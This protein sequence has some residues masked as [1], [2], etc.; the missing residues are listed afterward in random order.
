MRSAIEIGC[1]EWPTHIFIFR[2]R[3]IYV[4]VLQTQTC[5]SW[6]L[7]SVST[8]PTRVR[9]RTTSTA[10]RKPASRGFPRVPLRTTSR[11]PLVH[12]ELPNVLDS[13]DIPKEIMVDL[14]DLWEWER[15]PLKQVYLADGTKVKVKKVSSTALRT[16]VDVELLEK[17]EVTLNPEHIQ[18]AGD[19]SGTTTRCVVVRLREFASS[20]IR[21]TSGIL[22]C[23][24]TSIEDHAAQCCKNLILAAFYVSRRGN[25]MP[26]RNKQF[27]LEMRSA[28]GGQRMHEVQC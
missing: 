26:C 13:L 23:S 22:S 17:R 19:T 8:S 9:R 18:A 12:L 1:G 2:N 4:A 7:E 15:I 11:G 25:N 27:Q 16:S 14:V 24:R 6:F 28:A 3:K 20:S 21:F 5:R 10:L